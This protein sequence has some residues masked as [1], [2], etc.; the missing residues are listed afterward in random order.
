[1]HWAIAQDLGAEDSTSGGS[2]SARKFGQA[3][4]RILSADSNL[5]LSG[6]GGATG[7]LGICSMCDDRMGEAAIH[8]PSMLEFEYQGNVM[9]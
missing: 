7:N 8:E 2:Y 4:D 1:M 9:R 6:G 3:L 5:T